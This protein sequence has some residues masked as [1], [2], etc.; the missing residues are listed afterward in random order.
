VIYLEDGTNK[1]DQCGNY[2]QYVYLLFH[3]AIY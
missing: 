3:F 1:N 2:S